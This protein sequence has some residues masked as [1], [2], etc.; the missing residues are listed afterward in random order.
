MSSRN[1][2]NPRS[3][4]T[5]ERRAAAAQN[6]TSSTRPRVPSNNMGGEQER[7]SSTTTHTRKQ[8]T[9]ADSGERRVERKEIRERDVALRRTRSPLKPTTESRGNARSRTEKS[10]RPLDRTSRVVAT[11]AR[12]S[13]EVPQS[14]LPYSA[15]VQSENEAMEP[16]NH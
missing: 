15:T 8:S 9:A 16:S 1:P 14:M 6:L 12:A 11:A 10:S 7:R 2:P 13:P 4:S 3:S 5:A